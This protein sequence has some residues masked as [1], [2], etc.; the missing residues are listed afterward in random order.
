MVRQVKSIFYCLSEMTFMYKSNQTNLV[1]KSVNR[2]GK[3]EKFVYNPM[4]YNHYKTDTPRSIS[5][6][7]EISLYYSATPIS[8]NK[9]Q[10][11]CPYCKQ[12]SPEF[13]PIDYSG[14]KYEVIHSP[15]E[16]KSGHELRAVKFGRA[17][18]VRLFPFDRISCVDNP[19]FIM[20]TEGPIAIP[21]GSLH[22]IRTQLNGSHGEATNSDDVKD[23]KGGKQGQNRRIKKEF[24]KHSKKESLYLSF[25]P[26][27]DFSVLS[28]LNFFDN[29]SEIGIHYDV[30][31]L[32]FRTEKE[33]VEAREFMKAYE[34]SSYSVRGFHNLNPKVQLQCIK[35][36]VATPEIAPD[37]Q[38]KKEEEKIEEPD[39]VIVA[40]PN[41]Y[42]ESEY[43]FFSHLEYLIDT[44]IG[45]FPNG[46]FTYD[47]FTDYSDDD[48]FYLDE[49]YH[50]LSNPKLFH[51][52]GWFE[53]YEEEKD[54]VRKL[55]KD[56]RIKMVENTLRFDKYVERG[57]D[58]FHAY[59]HYDSVDPEELL[60]F[61]AIGF[62]ELKALAANKPYV[63]LKREDLSVKRLTK[64]FKYQGNNIHF[65]CHE[66]DYYL[67]GSSTFPS[68]GW[69]FGKSDLGV[70]TEDESKPDYLKKDRFLM[71]GFRFKEHFGFGKGGKLYHYDEVVFGSD[72]KGPVE[73]ER[74]MSN[75]HGEVKSQAEYRYAKIVTFQKRWGLLLPK[76]RSVIFSVEL[77]KQML[78]PSN[79]N[80]GDSYF[81]NTERMKRCCRCMAAVNISKN[82]VLEGEDVNNNTFEIACYYVQSKLLANPEVASGLH[83]N[84]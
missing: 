61:I 83:L 68:F 45:K 43:F 56:V 25:K 3:N 84:Q 60:P 78:S 79:Y 63:K 33:M 54:G 52:S 71:T 32:K 6:S 69:S 58:L 2:G 77:L 70:I 16:L 18:R 80:V 46:V 14:C 15:S 42:V 12:N 5:A 76:T 49:F 65:D 36:W 40:K 35:T 23:N 8:V 4:G 9:I 48:S 44:D 29:I 24:I 10:Y 72:F 51:G 7:S 74:F 75:S 73:D 38:E 53:K 34:K 39:V 11:I 30:M 55:R 62:T 21:R 67:L 59:Y 17:A 47:R 22:R 57:Y 13:C 27:L 19:K 41:T 66:N 28:E 50:L 31:Y 26:K 37:K 20:K 81:T 1:N 64:Y 82:F